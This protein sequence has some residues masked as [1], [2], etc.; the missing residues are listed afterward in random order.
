MG[1]CNTLDGDLK[2]LSINDIC[3]CG[4]TDSFVSC[5][6]TSTRQLPY[7]SKVNRDIYMHLVAEPEVAHV[8]TTIL[9]CKT[10][11]VLESVVGAFH[12]LKFLR[13]NAREFG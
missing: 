11:R 5:L 8:A 13:R 6:D 4:L 12:F 9:G 3:K 2:V 7:T 10:R 1:H